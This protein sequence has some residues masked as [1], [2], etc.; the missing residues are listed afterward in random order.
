MAVW[1]EFSRPFTLVA[2]A[3][4]LLR[5]ALVPGG[6]LVFGF[7]GAPTPLAEALNELRT[8]RSGGHAWSAPEATQALAAAGFE[9]R[10]VFAEGSLATLVIGR[11]PGA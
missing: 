4:G 7:F 8:V 11:N 1:Y 3:L 5:Q 6:A 2:P 10:R 9:P